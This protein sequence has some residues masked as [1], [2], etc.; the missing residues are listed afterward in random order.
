VEPGTTHD[1]LDGSP[2]LASR[3]RALTA[4]AQPPYRFD[5]ADAPFAWSSTGPLLEIPTAD[6]CDPLAPERVIQLR[7]AFSP[8]ERWGTCYQVVNARSPVVG[9]A[10][11]RYLFSKSPLPLE[12]IATIAGFT[13]YRNPTT[14]PRF[15]FAGQVQP[16]ASLADAARALHAADFGPQTAIVEGDLPTG[17]WASGEVQV[18][19]YEPNRIRLRTRSPA[20]AFLVAAEA[21]Y[22]GWEAT[23]DGHPARLYP[24]D[25]AFRG[26]PVPAGEHTVEMRFVPRILYRSAALSCLAFLALA[27]A[28]IAGRTNAAQPLAAHAATAAKSN[29]PKS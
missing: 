1:S 16:V 25:V 12:P 27:W 2:E 15:F 3:L 22:P 10:N 6:G 9:L 8:G 28:L 17:P 13:I 18:V 5:M 11:V 20:G 23:I 21:W 19:T 7:L 29:P 14:L 26:L 4:A 24:T